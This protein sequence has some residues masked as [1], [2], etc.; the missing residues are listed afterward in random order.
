MK[1]KYAMLLLGAAGLLA[2]CGSNPQRIDPTSNRGVVST[3]KINA[4]DWQAAAELAVNS[5]LESQ[6]LKRNDGRKMIIALSQIRNTTQ[7]HVDVQILTNQVREAVLRSGQAQFTTT[8]GF[9]GTGVDDTAT[10]EVRELENSDLFNQ[11]TVKKRGTA[12][13]PDMSLA[14]QITQIRSKEG[15]M[16]ESY[17]QITLRLTDLETGLEAWIGSKEV[18]KQ[19]K[20]NL[21]G[22]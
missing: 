17:F 2:G 12:I 5:M 7:T 11:S 14:G 8:V 9:G 19:E 20:K 4:K 3:H 6:V 21:F 10:R 22:F 15:R 13:A 1:M 16:E 18:M